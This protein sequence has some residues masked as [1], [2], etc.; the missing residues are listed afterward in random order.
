MGLPGYVLLAGGVV[1]QLQQ[2]IALAHM[3]SAS[4]NIAVCIEIGGDADPVINYAGL[5][6]QCVQ[7]GPT[8]SFQIW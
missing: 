1:Y 8:F 3:F 2:W 4:T 6:S 7:L 5:D